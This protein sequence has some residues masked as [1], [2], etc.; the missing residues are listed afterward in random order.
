MVAQLK[1]LSWLFF[2]NFFI[3]SFTF[4]GGYVVIPMIRKY[5]VEKKA[6]ISDEK[7]MDLA[8]I[9]QSS[10][11]AIAVNLSVLAG[12]Q[13]AGFSGALISCIASVLPALILLSFISV[14]YVSFSQ[15]MAVSAILKG[16]ESGVAA[17]IVDLVINMY[18]MILEEKNILLAMLVPI[19]FIG[20]YLLGLNVAALLISSAMLCSISLYWRLHRKGKENV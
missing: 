3:S 10:P 1:K 9:A 18:Q 8:A 19:V 15:N 17:L 2:T 6:W 20:N 12:F 4:G 13:T 11:G 14:W 5:F 16:M 7:L